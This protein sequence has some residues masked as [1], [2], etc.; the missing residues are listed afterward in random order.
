M[1]RFGT[2][3]FFRSFL[4]LWQAGAAWRNTVQELKELMDF[5]ANA[6]WDTH[7]QIKFSFHFLK[8]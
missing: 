4:L 7:G 5:L 6:G 3:K 2:L 1:L 8:V